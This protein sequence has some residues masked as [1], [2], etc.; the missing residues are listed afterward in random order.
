MKSRFLIFF[1]ALSLTNCSL[2][3]KSGR[4]QRAYEKYVRKS[5]LTRVRQ[6]AKFR[7]TTNM[8][9]RPSEPSTITETAPE[10]PES[11]T[12]PESQPSPQ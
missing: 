3:T 1:L 2:L 4:Q 9:L 12:A 8:P 7:G 11:V 6:Q 5:S 10:S